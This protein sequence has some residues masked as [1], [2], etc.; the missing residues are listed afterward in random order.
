M[1][2]GVKLHTLI[3]TPQATPMAICRSS[4][5]PHAVRHRRHGRGAL[6]SPVAQVP[7]AGRLHLRLPGHS[8]PVQV[9]RAVRDAPPAARQDESQGDRREHRHVRHDRLAAQER[10]AQQ[11]PRR[12]ARHV[13]S[14]LAHR[15]GDARSAS[16]AQGRVAAGVAGR[17]VPRRR[18]PSQRRVPAELRLRVRGDDG[19]DEGDLR[20]SRS[21]DS[22]TYDWYLKLGSLSH[23]NEQ[24]LHGK[25]PTLERLRRRTRT[26]TRSGSGRPSRRTSIA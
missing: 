21:I 1:R 23:V 11:R 13:V 20:R 24:Y 6:A 16:G 17:H 18:F 2:D 26:T 19:D 22:D 10:A 25:I 8:R 9:G 4:C 5:Q 14:G 12:H 3:F 7:G 15:D